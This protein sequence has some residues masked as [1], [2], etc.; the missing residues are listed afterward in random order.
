MDKWQCGSIGIAVLIAIVYMGSI[1]SCGYAEKA[2][3][4]GNYE[5]LTNERGDIEL[6]S[7]GELIKSYKN[8]KILYSSSDTFA[9]W[10][11][12][13]DGEKIYWQGEAFID[14]K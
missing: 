3:D 5:S 13:S 4:R 10:F 8:V 11:K 1:M 14:L 6:Y 9:M 7:G 12:T 2:Y